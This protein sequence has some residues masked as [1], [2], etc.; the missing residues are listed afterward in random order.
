MTQSIV[1]FVVVAQLRVIAWMVNKV[2]ATIATF[3][4]GSIYCVHGNAEIYSIH[5]ETK[6]WTA[7]F[8]FGRCDYSL[9]GLWAFFF[10]YHFLFWHHAGRLCMCACKCDWFCFCDQFLH[11]WI[12][13]LGSI[14]AGRTMCCNCCI[15][16]CCCCCWCCRRYIFIY[17]ENFQIFAASTT[18]TLSPLFIVCGFILG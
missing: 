4:T 11:A 2:R 12:A 3:W 15:I 9:S 17:L 18:L 10:F 7:R 5:H 8:Q 13:S 1:I 14:N 6:I 16:F